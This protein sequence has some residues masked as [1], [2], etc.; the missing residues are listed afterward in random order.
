MLTL[1]HGNNPPSRRQFLQLGGLSALGLSLPALFASQ[2]AQAASSRKDVNCILVWLL[3]GPSHIDMYDLKPDAPAE[4][5]GEFQPVS[6]SVPGIQ[7][8]EHLPLLGQQMWLQGPGHRRRLCGDRGIAGC[9]ARKSRTRFRKMM[10]QN[11]TMMTVPMIANQY[12]KLPTV[13]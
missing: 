13:Y 11:G 9:Q 2:Q 7:I 10:N 8:C 6:T 12:F 3:G 5:R 4:I 1:L